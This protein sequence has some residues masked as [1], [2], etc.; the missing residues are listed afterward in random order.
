MLGVN[1]STEP[2][3]L[4]NGLPFNK[5]RLL[6][7]TNEFMESTSAYGFPHISRAKQTKELVFWAFLVIG[8][9]K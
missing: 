5:A 7:L 4:A 6:P 2:S 3:S 8:M 9:E 1:N